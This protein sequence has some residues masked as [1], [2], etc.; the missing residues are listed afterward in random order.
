[1]AKSRT[2]VQLGTLIP[3]DVYSGLVEY[4]EESGVPITRIVE[5]ALRAWL[6]IPKPRRK[7]NG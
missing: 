3:E 5:D 7:R 2:K 6:E 4:S 1:M